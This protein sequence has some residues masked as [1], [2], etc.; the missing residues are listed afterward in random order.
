MGTQ[1]RQCLENGRSLYVTRKWTLP[2]GWSYEAW[3][4]LLKVVPIPTLVLERHAPIQKPLAL[5]GGLELLKAEITP[6]TVKS[7]GRI[8]ILYQW[9]RRKPSSQD[10]TDMV[11]AVFIDRHGNYFTKDNVLWLHDIHE[12]PMGIAGQ[13][14]PGIL[15]EEK[16]ILFIPSDFPPGEYALAVGLRKRSPERESGEEPFNREFYER[17]SYQDLDKFLGRG[18]NG[19][20]VQFS[21]ESS[22]GCGRGALAGRKKSLSYRQPPFCAGGDPSN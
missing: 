1:I 14:D 15:Y 16:R 2:G 7:G 12:P 19:A 10:S 13:M 8:E 4:P 20:V 22:S 18:E 11:V 21:T 5:W 6:D 9:V 3:G 17:N